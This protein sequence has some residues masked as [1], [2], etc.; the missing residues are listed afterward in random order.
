MQV[1]R[2][3]AI[4]LRARGAA[5]HRRASGRAERTVEFD[6][7]RHFLLESD[8]FAGGGEALSVRAQLGRI[9]GLQVAVS[10]AIAAACLVISGANAAVSAF[11]GGAIGFLSSLAY[12]WRIAGSQTRSTDTEKGADPKAL[13]RAHFVGEVQKLALTVILFAAVLILYKGVATLP[14]LLTFIATLV[15]YWVAL[16]IVF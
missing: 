16:L 14:L 9:I 2:W 11:L 1:S 15:V 13:M 7:A 8:G 10:V 4:N 3:R 12:A 5:V 6:A